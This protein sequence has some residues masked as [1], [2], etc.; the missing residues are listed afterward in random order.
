MQLIISIL[1]NIIDYTYLFSF[2][3]CIYFYFLSLIITV[4]DAVQ[5]PPLS[6]PPVNLRESWSLNFFTKYFIKKNYT[7]ELTAN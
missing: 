5:S 4:F 3:I 2:N 7:F 1:T 6:G